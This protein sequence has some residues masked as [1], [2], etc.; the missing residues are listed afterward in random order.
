MVI[1]KYP[2][3]AGQMLRSACDCMRRL[4]APIQSTF[5]SCCRFVEYRIY[6]NPESNFAHT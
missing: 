5:G 1:E 6:M 3:I 4:H 2:R